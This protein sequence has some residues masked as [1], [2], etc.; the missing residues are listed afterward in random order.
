[1]ITQNGHLLMEGI[2]PEKESIEELLLWLH[3]RQLTHPLHT[4][5]LSGQFDRA[6]F[7]MDIASGLLA[8]PFHPE[9]EKYV[10]LFRP[11]VKKI[12]DWGGDPGGRIIFDK[13]GLN[14]HP[15]HS[16]KLWRQIVDGTSLPWQEEELTAAETLRSFLYEY[17][18]KQ[19]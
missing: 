14:Y 7:Y 1:M 3:T 16:F 9:Q 18:N 15:R 5:H 2:L 10:L 11:E 17:S 12:I 13:D 8:I 6:A 19:I 4:D